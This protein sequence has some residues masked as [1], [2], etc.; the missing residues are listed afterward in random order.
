MDWRRQH[1]VAVA[2]A[3]SNQSYICLTLLAIRSQH[4]Q[5][6]N[7]SNAVSIRSQHSIPLRM[8]LLPPQS[9]QL[10][11]TMEHAERPHDFVVLLDRGGRS[12][13]DRSALAL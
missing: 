2:D 9:P 4:V 5:R 6:R 10:P 3:V 13:L 7:M 12:G 1:D 8:P 11:R